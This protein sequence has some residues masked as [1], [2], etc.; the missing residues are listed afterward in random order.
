VAWQNLRQYRGRLTTLVF[1]V[2]VGSVASLVC[3]GLVG[4]AATAAQTSINEGVALRTIELKADSDRHDVKQ[5]H[6]EALNALRSTAHVEAVEPWA[7]VSF[8]IKTPTIGGLLVYATSVRPSAPPPIL[9]STRT[10]VF[11]LHTNEVLL[12]AD[13]QGKNFGSLVGQQIPISYTRKTGEGTGE[14]ATDTVTVVGVYDP[15]FA[16]DGPSAAYADV[17]AVV[18][19]ASAK[20]GVPAVDYVSTVGYRKAYVI[21]DASDNM[22]RR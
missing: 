8:G 12:P 16:I 11:P 2:V 13:S 19:W 5:L 4:H 1:A 7:Q 17:G 3:I 15:S 22:S 18:R 9:H 20:A 14:S 21:V 10:N 6:D